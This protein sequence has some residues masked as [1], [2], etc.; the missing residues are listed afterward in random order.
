[1]SE[2]D[3][4]LASSEGYDLAK[5]HRCWRIRRLSVGDRDD[6]LLVKI[7]PAIVGQPYGLGDRGIDRVLLLA[8]H[9]GHPLHPVSEWPVFV[10]V[11]RLVIENPETRDSISPD[12]FEVI[13]WAE[14][15]KTEA[16]A[17]RRDLTKLS[18]AKS[19]PSLTNRN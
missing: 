8:R 12:D 3:F 16:E 19:G 1:M 2:P 11:A 6:V 14:I 18:D 15:Y 7:D 5:P 13:A 4:Y 9:K 17:R 10:H